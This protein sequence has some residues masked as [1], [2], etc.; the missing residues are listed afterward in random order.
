MG[1][2]SWKGHQGYM[3]IGVAGDVAYQRDRIRVGWFNYG[4]LQP[5]PEILQ[6]V[7]EYKTIFLYRNFR[8]TLASWLEHCSRVGEINP[9]G[10]LDNMEQKYRSTKDQM[11]YL[12][13]NVYFYFEWMMKW[14][15]H[16]DVV[17]YYDDILTRPREALD[18]AAQ[19]LNYDL[20]QMVKSSYIRRSATYRSAQPGGWWH[21]F[22]DKHLERFYEIW[23]P[24]LK[25]DKTI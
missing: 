8:D 2:D 18:S 20:D 1:H 24:I 17:L 5:H 23:E 9:H 6:Q 15:E 12:I 14:A 19:L 13:E 4:H 10:F 25:W 7:S 11:L 16:A 21:H 3:N 22:N